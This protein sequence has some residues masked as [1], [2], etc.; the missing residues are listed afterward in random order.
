MHLVWVQ[1]S[2]ALVVCLAQRAR[3]ALE[4]RAAQ[5]VL[6][7]ERRAKA[8]Q[9]LQ[10][11]VD[12]PVLLLPYL[13]PPRR[14][15]LCLLQPRLQLAG[16]LL[17]RLL[18]LHP[19]AYLG[20]C[21]RNL[22]PQPAR[23]RLAPLRFAASPTLAPLAAAVLLSFSAAACLSIA[24]PRPSALRLHG[25]QLLA[26]RCVCPPLRRRPPPFGCSTPLLLC[27][28]HRRCRRAAAAA[29]AGGVSR[30]RLRL[31]SGCLW[32]RAL[33][34]QLL[35]RLHLRL[36]LHRPLFR[37]HCPLLR[38]LHPVDCRFCGH[39]SPLP[40]RPRPRRPRPRR[41]RSR[42][43]RGVMGYRRVHTRGRAN[44][45]RAVAAI[46]RQ[47]AVAGS[48][49]GCRLAPSARHECGARLRLV[50][51]YPPGLRYRLR[52]PGPLSARFVLPNQAAAR[53]DNDEHDQHHDHRYDR[54]GSV[55]LVGRRR[56]RGRE[57]AWRHSGSAHRP[58][59]EVST[60]DGREDGDGG[61]ATR[62]EWT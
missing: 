9:R 6:G 62:R 43:D 51:H 32:R 44:G 16:V 15:L 18:R 35:Q 13:D 2:G 58:R 10:Q 55:G 29:V 12:V 37:R 28:R 14:L 30:W 48:R 46:T 60:R 50:G 17:C 24:S 41:R 38:R 33:P 19:A 5:R 45:A 11:G 59:E 61:C 27:C 52:R 26:A 36:R 21:V 49:D 20:N 42:H 22:P 3:V 34:R 54:P 40:G 56:G 25:S 4:R 23:L 1:A 31:L 53:A 8:P 47:P 57:G 39:P 7:E